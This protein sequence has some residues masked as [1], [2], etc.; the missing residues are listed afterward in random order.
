[1]NLALFFEG[2]GQGVHSDVGGLYEDNHELADAARAFVERGTF[3]RGSEKGESTRFCERRTGS[4]R[5]IHRWPS[6][7]M[8]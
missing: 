1:M 3:W 8:R 5:F 2:T 7:R 6:S 4:K